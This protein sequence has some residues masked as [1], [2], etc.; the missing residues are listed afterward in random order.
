MKKIFLLAAITSLIFANSACTSKKIDDQPDATAEMTG[1]TT[2]DMAGVSEEAPA[3]DGATADA[4]PAESSGD[5]NEE[6]FGSED[7]AESSGDAPPAE[8]AVTPD[9]LAEQTDA[10]P[11]D[12]A[13]ATDTPSSDMEGLAANDTSG[14]TPTD[15]ATSDAAPSDS[16]DAPQETADSGSSLPQ[17]EMGGLSSEAPVAKASVP[18]QKIQTTPWTQGGI[19]LN[20]VYLARQGDTFKTVSTKVYGDASKVKE[21]RKANPTIAARSMKVGDKVY[22]NSPKRPTDNTILLTF[23][24]DS[25]LAPETY[26]SQPGDNIRTVSTRLLGDAQSW[27][28]VWAT[29]ADVESKGDLPEGT[30][31][32]YWAGE[33]PAPTPAVEQPMAQNEPP[34]PAEM[35]QEQMAAA[36]AVGAAGSTPPTDNNPPPPMPED[37]SQQAASAPPPAEE[38]TPQEPAV[39]EAPPPPMDANAAAATTDTASNPMA[40]ILGGEDQTMALMVGALLLIAA[41]IMFIIIRKRKSRKNIDF[42]T[43]THTQ[44]E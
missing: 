41:A 29:N 43:A 32:R 2:E 42:Q 37:V 23:Y 39:A 33:V 3:E 35:P 12:D 14:D 13:A 40:D 5:F 1:D 44:I 25:N 19:L 24:E 34:P 9:T 36:G 17:D 21:L 38:V 27:K 4:A 31:L 11:T 16:M 8:G 18:L 7:V 28:E 30:R 10:P 15:N 20:A 6:D 22:Y 26:V